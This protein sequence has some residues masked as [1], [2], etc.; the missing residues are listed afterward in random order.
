M[1]FGVWEGLQSMRNACGLQMDGFSAD[2][3]PY[4]SVSNHFDGFCDFAV[5][6]DGLTLFPKGPRTLRECRR[7]LGTLRECLYN[8][9]LVLLLEGPRT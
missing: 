6:S 4:G 8:D 7:G 1:G 9:G 2:F 5:V 3:D